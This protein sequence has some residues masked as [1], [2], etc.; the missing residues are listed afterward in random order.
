[1][2]RRLPYPS[3]GCPTGGAY[4]CLLSGEGQVENVLC[5]NRQLR[6]GHSSCPLIVFYDDQPAKLL[7]LTVI[8]RLKSGLGESNVRSVSWLHAQANF[9]VDYAERGVED[10]HASARTRTGRQLLEHVGEYLFWGTL[11]KICLFVLNEFSRYVFLDLDMVLLSPLDPLMALPMPDDTY[12]AAVGTGGACPRVVPWEPFNG[13][14]EVLR[15]SRQQFD[16]MMT[17]MCQFYKNPRNY[18]HTGA[19]QFK[20]VCLQWGGDTKKLPGRMRS[21]HKVCEVHLTDQSLFNLNFRSNYVRLPYSYNSQPTRW[22]KPPPVANASSIAVMHFIGDPKPWNPLPPDRPKLR[23]LNEKWHEVARKL[24]TEACAVQPPGVD[25]NEH[26]ERMHQLA[27]V[28]VGRR[29]K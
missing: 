22:K 8:M 2:W 7:P 5:L 25:P 20:Q 28:L 16:L 15:P 21:F 14:L 17:R 3:G 13:G 4:V 9:S 27:S 1:M 23:K 12:I 10:N 29:W 6:R 24:W 26:R 11:S 18:F 19:S